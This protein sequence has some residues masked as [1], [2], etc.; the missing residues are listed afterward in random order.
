MIP[1]I[2]WGIFQLTRVCILPCIFTLSTLYCHISQSNSQLF[3]LENNAFLNIWFVNLLNSDV[4]DYMHSKLKLCV[5]GC[6]CWILLD[7]KW[8]LV[9]WCHRL[10]SDGA[11][12]LKYD[13]W[14]YFLMLLLWTQLSTSAYNS[15]IFSNVARGPKLIYDSLWLYNQLNH[16]CSTL[17]YFYVYK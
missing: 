8:P 11:V 1:N 10:Y 7:L 12:I 15:N 16:L 13:L 5:S 2:N 9:F 3:L 14:K 17:M 4:V 6:M